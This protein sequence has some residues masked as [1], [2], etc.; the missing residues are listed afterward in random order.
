MVIVSYFFLFLHKKV[1][2]GY[3]LEAPCQG[4]SNEFQQHVFLW[5]TGENYPKIIT[6]ILFLNNSSVW[7]IVNLIPGKI[8]H[9]FFC[10]CPYH[11]AWVMFTVA[12]AKSEFTSHIFISIFE[13]QYGGFIHLQQ[14]LN[15]FAKIYSSKTIY[16]YVPCRAKMSLCANVTIKDP[17]QPVHL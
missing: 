6:K 16:I 3:S 9:F 7:V 11:L 13:N 15:T 12:M 14:T 2:C 17:D 1:C 5:R 4:A 8:S 10:P